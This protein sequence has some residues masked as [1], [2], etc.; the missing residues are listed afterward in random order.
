[1]IIVNSRR[2]LED[3]IFILKNKQGMCKAFDESGNGYVRSDA[4]VVTFLQKSKDA[5]RIYAQILNVRT[6]TD[7]GKDQ[8]ITFPNG[9]MQNRLIHETYEEIGLDPRD[10][11]YV[12]AHGT[13]T[14]VMT[15]S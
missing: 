14:K 10:V 3:N 1:V 7:G 11:S 4:C 15:S 2:N 5:R 13:G 8:G 12:E 9:A 6:N